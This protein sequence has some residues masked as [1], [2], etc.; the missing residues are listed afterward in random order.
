MAAPRLLA[1]AL[2]LCAL[3]TTVFTH[4]VS[5]SIT[6]T[7]TPRTYL[8]FPSSDVMGTNETIF[9]CANT[10][11]ITQ[12]SEIC[13]ATPDCIGFNTNGWLKK[14]RS[15]LAPYP[16]DVYL[17]AADPA[18]S[19]PPLLWPMPRNLT[20]GNV[21]LV[22]SSALS[23]SAVTPCA[24]LTA[25]FARYESI[26]FN[27]G[28][29]NG[30]AVAARLNA[31]LLTSI[32][33]AVANV[34]VPLD[35]GVDETYSLVVP[36]DGSAA[37]LTAATVWGALHGLQTLS[38]L[39]T[40]DFDAA[41]Y[42]TVSPVSITDGPAFA[43]RGIML[44]PARQFLPLPTLRGIVDAMTT[45]KMNTVHVHLLDCDSFPLQVGPPFERL[46]EGAFS[47]R[48]RY[49]RAEL[50]AFVEYSRV[51]GVRIIFE[52]DQPGHMGAMCK[53]VPSICPTPACSESYGGDVLD[54]SSA[55]TLPAMEAVV[56]TL[57]GLTID[58][59]LHLGGDEVG[60]ACWLNSPSVVKWMAANNISSGL[61]VYEYFVRESNAMALAQG[62]SPMRWEEVW[63]NFG[64]TLD[65][66]TIVHAWLSSAAVVSASNAGYRVVYSVDSD[67][68]LD[69]LENQWDVYYNSDIL[70]GVTNAS[71]V[72]FIL[73]G[74]VCMWG[75]TVDAASVQSVLWPRAA[76]FAE[77]LWTYDNTVTS[78]DYETVTRFAQLRC[79]LLERGVSAPLPG[80]LNAGD[81][82]P[83]WTVGS[84][85]GGYR[86][87]C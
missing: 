42:W 36:A 52:F 69:Y 67:S 62:K 3:S 10:T 28:D 13:D 43:W 57:A 22:V 56:S 59:V 11:D 4:T 21:S 68:Y 41:A 51:R 31:P 72:P 78:D 87:L 80:A 30:S 86:K 6:H 83:A 60:F 82:R 26:I 33:V 76:A 66:R 12:L 54:P 20:L 45:V 16:I 47:P 14:G 29:A 5:D 48:E 85:G 63:K 19:P 75:E 34:S 44:D 27:H 37:V 24:L 7:A 74:Q 2:A 79:T 81:M 18:P 32:R 58:S 61:G 64:T 15:S 9:P 40:F 38:Q 8:Y 17:L 49:T 46:W 23:F 53:G 25:A 35:L 1:L 73:G 50:A 55:D 84:C 39:V 71:A 70:A 65:R 77:R